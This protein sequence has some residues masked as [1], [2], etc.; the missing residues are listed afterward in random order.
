MG[1]W[2]VPLARSLTLGR[3]AATPAFVWVWMRL[4]AAP[5]EGA[6]RLALLAIYVYAVA[7]DLGDGPLAR[8]G[9]AV[10]ASWGRLDAF[11]DVAFNAAALAVAAWTGRIGPWAALGVAA[12]G[13]RFLWRCRSL[14]EG[15]A[16]PEDGPGKWAGVAFYALVGA[17]VADAAFAP[18]GLGSLLPWLANLAF[19]YTLC[20]L[21]RP[22]PR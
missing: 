8:R 7:S 5:Q 21:L 19:F 14:P 22:A 2:C 9:G 11:S 17:L 12:L 13:G 20:L 18:P 6:A 4:E 15:A 3:V 10:R 1:R 16:L